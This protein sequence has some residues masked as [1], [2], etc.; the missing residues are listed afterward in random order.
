[1]KLFDG[2]EKVC[3]PCP[4]WGEGIYRYRKPGRACYT[5][6]KYKAMCI[7]CGEPHLAQAKSVEGDYVYPEF[8]TR[9]CTFENKQY[10]E[11]QRQH[12]SWLGKN[13]SAEAVQHV[14][15]ANRKPR[16]AETIEKLAAVWR[17]RKHTEE[18]KAKQSASATGVKKDPEAVIKST[19]NR[20][21][22][23]RLTVAHN[24]VK[25]RYTSNAKQHDREFS[26]TD[27][28]FIKLIQGDCFYCGSAPNDDV[29]VRSRG[30]VCVRED[31]I[32]KLS[33]IDRV[34]S[35]VGYTVGNCV[36]ACTA[37][38]LAKGSRSASEFISWVLRVNSFTKER[39]ATLH[40][41][42]EVT[43]AQQVNLNYLYKRY[44]IHPITDAPGVK[45]FIRNTIDKD[46]FAKLIKMQ[47]YYCGSGPSNTSVHSRGKKRNIPA[48]EQTIHY[49]G[50]DRM[51]SNGIYE[52]T[53][54]VPC[55]IICN[56]AKNIL[57][58]TDFYTWV[59]RIVQFQDAKINTFAV[60]S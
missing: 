28:E 19:T 32:F 27:D 49:N 2:W 50:L 59:N 43:E 1:M 46:D 44:C 38:N 11:E 36:T 41:F 7:G 52:L 35:A 10:T 21:S 58:I 31:E 14:L 30:T 39:P 5:Y 60:Q 29:R 24:K 6:F 53:N 9:Q 23:D 17:G 22:H 34:D 8:C 54:V 45:H 33:G 18:T 26:L 40:Y 3:R 4:K 47:C 12:W 16:S 42:G 55:C 15:E 37:C 51:D 20:L 48:P 56:R 13:R 57:S 25:S